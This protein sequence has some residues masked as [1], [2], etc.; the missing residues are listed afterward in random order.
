MPTLAAAYGGEEA[1]RGVADAPGALVF[2]VRPP[3]SSVDKEDDDA[4]FSIFSSSGA[5]R[6]LTLPGN[7]LS[8]TRASKL[9][10]GRPYEY[11]KA[12]GL[13][14]PSPPIGTGISPLT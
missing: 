13:Y 10:G 8:R 2:W 3:A 5:R 6:S 4:D 11:A 1:P 12:H 9:L 14:M 7:G